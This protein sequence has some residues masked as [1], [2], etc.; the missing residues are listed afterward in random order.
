MSWTNHQPSNSDRFGRKPDRP[1]DPMQA[2]L[3][4]GVVFAVCVFLTSFLP[5]ALAL[6][7]LEGLLFWAAMGYIAKALLNGE[8][9]SRDRLT[10]WDQSLLLLGASI[11][12]GLFVDP[13][14][15]QSMVAEYGAAPA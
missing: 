6:L 14:D 15:L 11:A 5:G 2:L 12:V 7:V 4:T 3:G 1:D 8:S 13:S 9:W 10:S